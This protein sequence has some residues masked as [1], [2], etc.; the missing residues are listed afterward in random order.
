MTH[1][2]IP[3]ADLAKIR[4]FLAEPAL[5]RKWIGAT[6]ALALLDKAQPVEVVAWKLIRPD[7]EGLPIY[8]TE[9]HDPSIATPLYGSKE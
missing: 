4:E 5:Q 8:R 9:V 7:W 2:L 3:T 1:H 6:E